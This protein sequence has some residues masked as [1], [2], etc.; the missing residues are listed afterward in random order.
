ME[1][2]QHDAAVFQFYP[3]RGSVALR[4]IGRAASPYLPDWRIGWLL[5]ATV[6]DAGEHLAAGSER[7]AGQRSSVKVHTGGGVGLVEL[8]ASARAGNEAP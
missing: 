5:A 6:I 1:L 8:G 7:E 3:P 2:A 4:V